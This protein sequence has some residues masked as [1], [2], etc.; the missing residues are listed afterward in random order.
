MRLPG[1]RR[2]RTDEAYQQVPTQIICPVC[3]LRNDALARFCRNCGLPLGA[4]RDPVRGTTSRRADLPSEHGTG[5]AA[6]VGLI[7]AVVVLAGAG[8][9]ILRSNTNGGTAAASPTPVATVRPSG[10]PASALSSAAPSGAIPSGASASAPPSAR[11]SQG[12]ASQRPSAAPS[13]AGPSASAQALVADTGFTC[14][15]ATFADPTRGSWRVTRASWANREDGYDRVTL[16]L[17]R[18]AGRGRTELGIESMPA[19]RVAAQTGLDQPPGERAVVVRLDG[20]ALIRQAIASTATGLGIVT[21]VN[22]AMGQGGRVYAVLS[23]NGEGC[24]RLSAPGWKDAE[25]VAVGDVVNLLI[26]VRRR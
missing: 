25:N 9:L 21:D 3:G 7:A 19:R 20:S 10:A 2:G 4:P 15:T 13:D 18:E 8:F 11:P 17:T 6:V 14:K 1:F 12:L 26:D 24:H 5:I 23:T 22:V 16:E